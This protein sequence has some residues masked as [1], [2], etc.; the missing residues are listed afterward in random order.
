MSRGEPGNSE[1]EAGIE[2]TDIFITSEVLYQLSYSGAAPRLQACAAA[3]RPTS[4]K[5]CF[6]RRPGP[7]W[8]LNG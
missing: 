5:A 6:G 4:G 2:P 3:T 8:S 1:P 7:G